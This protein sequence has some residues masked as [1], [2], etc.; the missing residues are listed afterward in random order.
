LKLLESQKNIARET[1]IA[2]WSLFDAMGGE[3]SMHS[4]VDANPPLATAD[5]MHFNST[6][7]QKVGNIIV[8]A[9]LEKYK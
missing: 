3:N 9:L 6:G 4:W 7:A 8:E 2:Y 1:D 5:H